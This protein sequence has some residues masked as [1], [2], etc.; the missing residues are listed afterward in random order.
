MNKRIIFGVIVLCLAVAVWSFLGPGRQRSIRNAPPVNPTIVAFGDSL[1]SGVGAGQG[2]SYP[3]QLSA[4]IGR[5]IINLGV[6]GET[7]QSAMARLDDVLGYNPGIV[8]ITL[9][10][11]DLKNGVGRQVAFQNLSF[12]IGVFQQEGAMVILGGIDIPFWGRDFGTGYR[13]T[14]DAMG[15]VLVP[16]IYDGILGKPGLMSDRIHPN[17]KG[18]GI[19]AGHFF[20]A[21]KPYL[22]P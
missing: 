10:G 22:A 11:N 4:R 16:D 15:V 8:L 20:K 13:E 18:Y 1:T 7:T 9:G 3:S 14:A 6:P 19:M 21:L 5:K 2:G 17:D 12:I